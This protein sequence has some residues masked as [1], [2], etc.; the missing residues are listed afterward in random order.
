MNSTR[1]DTGIIYRKLVRDKI[2]QIIRE[3]GKQP[4]TRKIQGDELRQAIAAKIIE[5]AYELFKALGRD[6]KNANWLS[7]IWGRATLSI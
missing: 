4:F 3:V 6:N 5:E 2:P 7:G 1:K